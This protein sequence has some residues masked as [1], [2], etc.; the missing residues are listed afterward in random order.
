MLSYASLQRRPRIYGRRGTVELT[1][2]PAPILRVLCLPITRYSAAFTRLNCMTS[3]TSSLGRG[4]CSK[5]LNPLRRDLHT[6]LMSGE[7]CHY[8]NLP[9]QSNP[10]SCARLL[11][12]MFLRMLPLIVYS[13]VRRSAAQTASSFPSGKALEYWADYTHV[14]KKLHSHPRSTVLDVP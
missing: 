4:L 5:P 11:I 12:I 9:S 6:Y 14:P 3:T 2:R 10:C 7:V 1:P 8:D 13:S